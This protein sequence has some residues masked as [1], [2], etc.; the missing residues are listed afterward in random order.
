MK[1]RYKAIGLMS[2]SSLDGVD[3]AFCEFE[4]GLAYIKEFEKQLPK[5][6]DHLSSRSLVV[7]Y[8]L[9]AYLL[10]LNVQ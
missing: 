7:F 10:Q 6:L 1:R 5:Y 3:I 8:H 9:V 4:K 2:G